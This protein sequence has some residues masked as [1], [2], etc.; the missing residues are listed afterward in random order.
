MW[1]FFRSFFKFIIWIYLFSQYSTN[2]ALFN[3]GRIFR[4][5]V[6]IQQNFGYW[7][8]FQIEI[9]NNTFMLLILAWCTVF[10]DIR[11]ITVE[12]YGESD[13]HPNHHLNQTPFLCP[14]I[15]KE[16]GFR[17]KTPGKLALLEGPR[18]GIVC[19]WFSYCLSKK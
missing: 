4:Y 15:N 9:I 6:H 11:K 10:L 18:W 1:S 16:K 5:L 19:E 17:I 13:I 3:F 2:F 12:S 8:G 14:S 7:I